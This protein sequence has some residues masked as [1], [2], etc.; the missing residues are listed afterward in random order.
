MVKLLITKK[1]IQKS[2]INN[3]LINFDYDESDYS[4]LDRYISEN[5][6][7]EIQ[8]IEPDIIYIKDNLSSN[9]LELYGL[10][11]AYHIRLSKELGDK[12]YLPIV[13]LSDAD[14]HVLNKLNPMARVLFT[15]NIFIVKNTKEAVENF[16]LP[17]AYSKL[18]K[19]NFNDKFLKLITVEPPEN[20]TSHSIANK[21][22]I[23]RWSSLL[24]IEDKESIKKNKEKISYMLYYKYLRNKYI[25]DKD[26][27]AINKNEEIE[28]DLLFIDDR[29]KDGWNDIVEDYIS[30]HYPN[31]NFKTLEENNDNTNVYSSIDSIK[32]YVNSAINKKNIPN[33]ILLDLRLLEDKS[34]SIY[35]ISGVKILEYIKELNPSIQI[36]MFTA[37]N[38][39]SI[40]DLLYSKGILGYVKKDA[41]TDKYK[42]SRNGFNKLHTLIEK[43]IEKKYL[44][45]IW[46]IQ[47]KICTSKIFKKELDKNKEED[48]KIEEL[49]T[50]VEMV[51]KILN[52]NMQNNFTF[53]MF[54]IFKCI[55]IIT[56]IYIEER[57]RNAYW[58]NDP[59]T[60]IDNTGYYK[61]RKNQDTDDLIHIKN[62]NDKPKKGCGNLS[63]ENKI[64]SI[65]HQKL[66]IPSD[67]LHS[68]I[69]C[70][71]CVRNHAMHQDKNYED[72][73][74][75]K[76]VVGGEVSS[77]QIIT[78]FK[79]LQKI[80]TKINKKLK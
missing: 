59:K 24:G 50:T 62:E 34:D 32:K 25:L 27:V 51:F 56:Y 52:S 71:V 10:R 7:T 75:C 4:D 9:Y 53:A 61:N 49:K 6:I 66:G 69:K 35:Q 15:K 19:D 11:V 42:A 20:T 77:E 37:S 23:E 70:I 31:I 8:G 13:I 65:M 73:D 55:E 33:I 41:P 78:W 40:L 29:G 48:K 39:G 30:Q 47:T 79:M 43:G 38:D 28:G 60:C 3:L 16:K 44:Q 14:S 12:R 58:K 63:V 26:K 57:D 45:E 1:S 76:N 36:I 67:E 18:T 22:A 54:T 68:Q 21:W 72:I 5:I 17:Q 74:F 46:E 80:L 64:R 2:F